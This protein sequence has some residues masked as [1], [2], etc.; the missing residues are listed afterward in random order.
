MK[1]SAA[2][3]MMLLS[4]GMVFLAVAMCCVLMPQCYVETHC[5][6][7][8]GFAVSGSCC[9]LPDAGASSVTLHASHFTLTAPETSATPVAPDAIVARSFQAASP[10]PLDSSPPVLTLRI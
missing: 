4:P 5:H 1:R 8:E 9:S 3:L 10:A 2:I 7:Q 6:E